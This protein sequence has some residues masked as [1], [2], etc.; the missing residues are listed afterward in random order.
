MFQLLYFFHL[1]YRDALMAEAPR[2]ETPI[3]IVQ[4]S[5]LS[6][7][8]SVD[9]LAQLETMSNTDSITSGGV[10]RVK[11]SGS[12]AGSAVGSHSGNGSSYGGGKNYTDTRR[13]TS[14]PSKPVC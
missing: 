5:A 6:S 2:G 1:P 10:S 4:K 11:N 7:A 14:Y 13:H 3:L 8:M 9:M 12:R